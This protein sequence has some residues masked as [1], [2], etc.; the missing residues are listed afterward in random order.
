MFT[1]SNS[2]NVSKPKSTLFPTKFKIKLTYL[3]RGK[4][5]LI[6]AISDSGFN[7][8]LLL[9]HDIYSKN[10]LKKYGGHGYSHTFE[11]ILMRMEN[12]GMEK[13]KIDEII[14]KNPQKILTFE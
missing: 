14:I 6:K 12:I 10:R 3:I 2:K 5:E 9:G 7:N 11:N 4:I 13:R 1:D 8:K